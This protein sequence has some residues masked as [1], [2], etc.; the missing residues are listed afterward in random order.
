MTDLYVRYPDEWVI[1]CHEIFCEYR[2]YLQE[3]EGGKQGWT[4]IRN[5]MMVKEDI[6]SQK[7][8][9]KRDTRLSRQNLENWIERTGSE[10]S[11]IDRGAF[12]FI[13]RYLREQ[14]ID[15]SSKFSFAVEKL[16]Q[17]HEN[18]QADALQTIFQMRW[19]RPPDLPNDDFD[20]PQG[21]LYLSISKRKF[22]VSLYVKSQV[23]NFQRVI[24]FYH[25]PEYD[26]ADQIIKNGYKFFG[27]LHYIGF[28]ADG[29]Q[30]HHDGMKLDMTH[31][32]CLF[33][34]NSGTAF[35]Y[36]SFNAVGC[37]FDYSS[38]I[39]N[40]LSPPYYFSPSDYLSRN[41]SKIVPITDF[42][43]KRLDI[44]PSMIDERL[45]PIELTK[46]QISYLESL[47]ERSFLW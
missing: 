15:P 28:K 18:K 37:A 1:C 31:I 44:F 29:S 16:L 32:L 39:L 21:K 6:E 38:M 35:N 43:V 27:F 9:G 23:K 25:S 26:N 46:S 42:P 36:E 12:Y 7:R 30:E 8:F 40:P 2:N 20:K 45:K 33:D 24:G 41:P 17:H 11:I 13:D 4:A 47:Q 34:R 5:R 22:L 19:R 10:R 14:L 3:S